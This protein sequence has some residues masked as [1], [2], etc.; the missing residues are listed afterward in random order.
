MPSICTKQRLWPGILLIRTHLDCHRWSAASGERPQLHGWLICNHERLAVSNAI[1]LG[2]RETSM[3]RSV[4][5]C[6]NVIK[7]A[8]FVSSWRVVKKREGSPK[9]DDAESLCHKS[10][11]N[12]SHGKSLLPPWTRYRSEVVGVL[13]F[14]II[15]NCSH[16]RSGC[17]RRNMPHWPECLMHWIFRQKDAGWSRTWQK[18]KGKQFDD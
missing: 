1:L 6:F 11:F 5:A 2:E 3:D 10:P 9:W 15:W 17:Q 16:L 18:G 12:S 13:L 8:P 7:S 14:W 4:G